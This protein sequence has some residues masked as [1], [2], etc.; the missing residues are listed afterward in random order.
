MTKQFAITTRNHIPGIPQ[1]SHDGETSGGFLPGVTILPRHAQQLA[2]YVLLAGAFCPA[3]RCT[4]HF[5]CTRSLLPCHPGVGWNG[6]IV[7]QGKKALKRRQAAKAIDRQRDDGN[8]FAIRLAIHFQHVQCVVRANR[9]PII[10]PEFIH[11]GLGGRN[12]WLT[13]LLAKERG[14]RLKNDTAGIKLWRPENR[15][16]RGMERRIDREIATPSAGRVPLLAVRRFP[17]WRMPHSHG[18]SPGFVAGIPTQCPMGIT[19]RYGD[20]R[21]PSA[22]ANPLQSSNPPGPLTMQ[23]LQDVRDFR[24]G[25]KLQKLRDVMPGAHHWVVF[26][27]PDTSPR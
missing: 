16:V 13:C 1:Q 21:Q 6:P 20:M 27:L 3:I 14:R 12:S 24:R 22:S 23:S 2:R 25:R 7:Q 5:C 26:Q 18:C 19:V 9:K 10:E 8:Q 15:N 11:L 4:Q 17:N